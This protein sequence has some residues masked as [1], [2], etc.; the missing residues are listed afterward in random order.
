MLEPDAPR[1][2]RRRIDALAERRRETAA[3][4]G[5][6]AVG[7]ARITAVAGQDAWCSFP[8]HVPSRADRV[9]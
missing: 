6:D 7:Q 5:T 1:G 2:W 4:N 8:D 9:R 3:R